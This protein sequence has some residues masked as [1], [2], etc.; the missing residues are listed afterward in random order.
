[1][2]FVYFPIW[3]VFLISVLF[4]MKFIAPKKDNVHYLD[5]SRTGCLKGILALI[6]LFDHIGAIMPVNDYV[7]S[8]LHSV[9]F[10]AVAIF[11]F[12]SG[13]AVETQRKK[14]DDY[15]DRSFIYKKIVG[16]LVPMVLVNGIYLLCETFL[17]IWNVDLSGGKWVFYLFD[18]FGIYVINSTVWYIRSLFLL[19]VV[20]FL[21]KK[22]VKNRVAADVGLIVFTTVL[23]VLRCLLWRDGTGQDW[24]MLYCFSIGVLWAEYQ[25]KIISFV[26]KHYISCLLGSGITTTVFLGLFLIEYESVLGKLV[27]R[28]IGTSCFCILTAILLLVIDVHNRFLELLGKISLEIYLIHFLFVNLLN[29]K[30]GQTRFNVYLCIVCT[31]LAACV[32]NFLIK[33]IK[34]I[35]LKAGTQAV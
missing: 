9:G 16:L 12:F 11:F 31:V 35:L 24:G 15:L 18:L 14:R 4:G 23:T 25:E 13:Y 20:Y 5:K 3:G 27:F 34:T 29:E 8:M 21:L 33:K 7:F 26:K 30:I 10:L 17:G 1:M 2:D 32:L 19:L 28:N 22:Y 6:I